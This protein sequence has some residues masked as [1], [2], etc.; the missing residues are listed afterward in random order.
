[1]SKPSS[2]KSPNS[3]KDGKPG[4]EKKLLDLGE[5]MERLDEAVAK[6]VEDNPDLVV[7]KYVTILP[8]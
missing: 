5:L 8:G 2:P 3:P 4:G 1:M 6:N 7:T